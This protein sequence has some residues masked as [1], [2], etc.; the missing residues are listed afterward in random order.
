MTKNIRR[1][2]TLALAAI[3][4]VAA[5][6]TSFAA[7]AKISFS[8]PSA[9]LG[10]EFEMRVKVSGDADLSASSKVTLS[11]DPSYL[12]FVSGDYTDGGAGTLVVRGA[13]EQTG[14]E[15]VYTLKFKALAA[16]S[17]TVG[18]KDSETY[19]SS[20]NAMDIAHA[21]SGTV[22]IAGEEGASV[23]ANLAG[24]KI[25]P[26]VLTP[27]FTPEVTDY[28]AIVGEDC[29][30]VAV[31]AP[32]ADSNA[33]VVIS[34]NAELQ[35]GENIIECKVTAQDGSTTKVYKIVVTK[36]EGIVD[37]GD[38]EGILHA[39][40]N[41]ID[42]EVATT[43]DDS[44]LPE[45]FTATT[46]TYK[47]QEVKAAANANGLT[48]M[49]LIGNDG[50]GDFYIYDELTD[51]WSPYARIN[52]VE[53]SIT[54]IPLPE[55]V[56]V[57]EGFAETTLE[58]NG[59][60]VRGWVWATDEE[61]KYCIVYGMNQDG[62]VDFYRYDMKEKTIQRYF[63]DPAVASSVDETE[64]VELRTAYQ[65]L[66]DAYNIRT[67]LILGIA[68]IAGI[69]LVALILVLIFSRG[70][71]GSSPKS[72]AK[73]VKKQSEQ[74]LRDEDEDEEYNDYVDLY[75]IN[76]SKPLGDEETYLRG[77]EDQ[78]EESYGKV[79]EPEPEASIDDDFEVFDL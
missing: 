22:T 15:Y 78:R 72:K 2:I 58:L 32:T 73:N 35:M 44:I 64:L 19:D 39:E 17:T 29:E 11:Y 59:K 54:I 45:D 23:N 55:S 52:V 13:T 20:E 7:S 36:Q 4:I 40:I 61:Q 69:L 14:K 43:F 50:S 63:A 25:S 31:S 16:G 51:T 70:G 38:A 37:Y 56:E 71:G 28:T 42:Y 30:K 34:G 24:L 49:Y 18:I 26:S 67:Y 68:V 33:K 10:E 3:M 47:G 77:V 53:K 62:E 5:A 41:G 1:I 46:Y 79:D 8:D 76:D 74:K 48:V 57:P 6:F 27:A 60:R 66:E 9:N 21:G 65:D 12:E 75:E